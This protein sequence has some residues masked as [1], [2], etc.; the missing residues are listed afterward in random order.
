M[1]EEVYVIPPYFLGNGHLLANNL[2][3]A[4]IESAQETPKSRCFTHIQVYFNI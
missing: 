2:F 4:L 1:V 3:V